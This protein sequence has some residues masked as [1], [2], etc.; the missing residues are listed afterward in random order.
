MP[1]WGPALECKRHLVAV[2]IFRLAL[3]VWAS[4]TP[5]LDVRECS[6]ASA[7]DGRGDVVCVVGRLPRLDCGLAAVVAVIG[8]VMK[9][10]VLYD[11]EVV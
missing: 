8:E 5:A 2:H 9:H 4:D 1:G 11:C 7:L 3:C 6:A 10:F